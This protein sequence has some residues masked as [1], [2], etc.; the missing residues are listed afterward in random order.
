MIITY[1]FDWKWTL[2]IRDALPLN[3]FGV[4]VYGATYGYP[5]VCRKAAPT[6]VFQKPLN[7]VLPRLPAVLLL[8]WV[9]NSFLFFYERPWIWST[10]LS[11]SRCRIINSGSASQRM[12][13]L[14]TKSGSRIIAASLTIHI[15]ITAIGV[16][17]VVFIVSMTETML[18][19]FYTDLVQACNSWQISITYSRHVIILTR[20][21][22]TGGEI[23]S[24]PGAVRLKRISKIFNHSMHDRCLLWI[25]QRKGMSPMSFST[26]FFIYSPLLLRSLI[27]SPNEFSDQPVSARCKC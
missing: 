4:L 13:L 2:N 21:S 11:H 24:A 12:R 7:E 26:N 22:T 17:I 8:P 5:D 20:V 10:T 25:Q 18:P 27:T 19:S 23:S 6:V 1:G 9:S 14:I 16:M 3:A 15:I